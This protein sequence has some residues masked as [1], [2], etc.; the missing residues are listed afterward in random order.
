MGRVKTGQRE[1]ALHNRERFYLATLRASPQCPIWRLTTP[2]LALKLRWS[3]REPIMQNGSRQELNLTFARSE[4]SLCR[5]FGR[6]FFL[7]RL[8]NRR[9][10]RRPRHQEVR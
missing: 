9:A 3:D 5:R 10:P 2:S 7:P 6:Q 8:S 4:T 1:L